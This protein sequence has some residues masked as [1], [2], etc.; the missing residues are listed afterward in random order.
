MIHEHPVQLLR[1]LHEPGAH[2]GF[3]VGERHPEPGRGEGGAEGR[4]G[5]AEHLDDIGPDLADHRLQALGHAPGLLGMGARADTQMAV[6]L[7]DAELREEDAGH[8][9][10]VVL[11]SVHHHLAHSPTKRFR[12]RRMLH[13]LRSDPDH[14]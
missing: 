2:P 7:A 1:H 4:V 5:V 14:R 10:V 13:E 11:S 8:R 9:M 12:Y 6:G 3:D